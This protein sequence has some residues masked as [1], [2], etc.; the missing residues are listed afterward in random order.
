MKKQ[1]LILTACVCCLISYAQNG[2]NE[3]EFFRKYDLPASFFNPSFNAKEYIITHYDNL[4]KPD[5]KKILPPENLVTESAKLFTRKKMLDKAYWLL[6]MNIENYPKNYRLYLE[7][8]DY[9]TL[10]GDKTRAFVYYSRALTVKYK[11]PSFIADSSIKIDAEIA[12]DYRQLSEQTGRKTLPPQYLIANI[13]FNLLKL[14]KTDQALSLFKLNYENYPANADAIDDMGSYYDNI[15]DSTKAFTY[16]A[17]AAAL[18]NK[19]PDNFFTPSF[20]PVNYLKTYYAELSKSSAKKTLPP[21][22]LVN[23]LGYIFMMGKMF[24]KT[25][26]L[27][28]LNIENYPQ[29]ENVFD[30]M[31]D[32]YKATA[33]KEKEDEYRKQSLAIAN[34][35][36]ATQG[37]T[38]REVIADTTFDTRVAA[39]ICRVNCP[40]ILFDEAHYNY[41]TASGRYKPFVNLMA[42]DGFKVIPGQVPFTNQSLAQVNVVV[43]ASPG[44]PSGV[45]PFAEIKAL[46]NWVRQGGSLLAITDH[47]NLGIDELLH[48]FGIETHEINGTMDSLHGRLRDDGITINPHSIVF[49]EKDNLLGNHP[50]IRGRNT[51]EKI[52]VVK[53]FGGRTV[54]GP[55]GSAVLLKLSESAIDFIVVDLAQ[56]FATREAVKTKGIRTHGVAFSFGKG[57]VVAVGEAAM[58]TAQLWPPNFAPHGAGMNFPGSDNRQFALNIMRWLTGYLK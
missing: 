43:I 2:I 45:I 25:E 54:I 26:Q 46:N 13:A 57:K 6:R 16:R 35:T 21:E 17:R 22:N 51:S 36:R 20:N 4:P 30:S 9:Y 33:D 44:V 31:A 37:N 48:S 15:G 38:G 7:M 50:I 5:G 42:N 55:P 10:T 14:K 32:Y 34:N 23:W 3:K 11:Q 24:D 1:I 56:R 39:P 19:L 28:K 40:I 49:T 12:D 18:D 41:H 52:K 29:S 53:T 58:L 47:D 8:G 27:F